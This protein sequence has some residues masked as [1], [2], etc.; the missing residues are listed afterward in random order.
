MKVAATD[1]ATGKGKEIIIN[2]KGKE[3]I[4]PATRT[5]TMTEEHIEKMIR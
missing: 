5:W 3:I 2:G 4:V 1:K